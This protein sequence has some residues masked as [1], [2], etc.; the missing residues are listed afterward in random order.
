[1]KKILALVL[2]V[3]MCA[4][5]FAACAPATPV[6]PV[7]TAEESAVASLDQ[8]AS[9]SDA[10]TGD[11]AVAK[12]K[13]AG[14]IVMLTNSQFAPYE[15]M[16]SSNKVE[17]IDVDISQAI[18]D[19]LGV[20]LEV[21]DMDFDGLIAALVS[22]KGDFVAAGLTVDPERAESVDFSETYADAKQLIV[23]TKE[24]PKVAS[25]DDL[26][27]K[28]IGVQLGTTGDLYVSNPENVADANVKPYKGAPEAALDLKNGKLDAVVIDKLT[29]E[30]IVASNDDLAIVDMPST[31]EQYA[32]AVVK[33]NAALKEVIDKVI[34]QL[35]D[36]GK[37]A[38]FTEKHVEASKVQ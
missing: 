5:V 2:I 23:V 9:A 34:K 22:G 25:A 1:M 6:A 19:E 8:D 13:A 16:G 18:A 20:E 4:A 11:D 12:I 14:K 24:A 29:A 26:A 3:V 30:N 17:G 28:T 37:I 15:Y 27:G 36:S 33:G 7:E 21:V 32:I 31:D 38:E 35:Q 10:A